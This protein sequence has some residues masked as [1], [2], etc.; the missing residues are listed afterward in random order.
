MQKYPLATLILTTPSGIEIKHLPFW[1]NHENGRLTLQA[2]LAKA[3]LSS[4]NHSEQQ[5]AL[6][7]FNGPNAYVSPNVYP[8]K[9]DHH[10]VVPTWNYAAVH[11]Y[12]EFSIITDEQWLLTNVKQLTNQQEVKQN[13]P[14]SIDQA[15]K[16]YIEKM[17]AAIVGIEINV[18]RLEG[19]LKLSQNQPD[20]NRRAVAESFTA[21]IATH[22]LGLLMNTML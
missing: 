22:D 21:Q 7:V 17:I 11:A 16:D 8:H 5:Q 18:N 19:Q 10:R 13:Q 3:N 4:H 2:H 15:P 20:I 1:I 9:V 14:W 6:I 12:G